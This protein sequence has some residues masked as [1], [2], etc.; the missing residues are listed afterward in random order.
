M[1]WSGNEIFLVKNEPSHKVDA[2]CGLLF[3]P[4]QF[5]LQFCGIFMVEKVINWR[6]SGRHLNSVWMQRSTLFSAWKAKIAC[7]HSRRFILCIRNLFTSASRSFNFCWFMIQNTRKGEKIVWWNSTDFWKIS[8]NLQHSSTDA[9]RSPEFRSI[10]EGTYILHLWVHVRTQFEISVTT[11][12][13]YFSLKMAIGVNRESIW[14]WRSISTSSKASFQSSR[15][16]RNWRLKRW[17]TT[18]TEMNLIS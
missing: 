7:K 15:A 12:E 4:W 10:R 2:P 13:S 3:W 9:E 11:K 16:I 8:Q 5:C 17:N 1:R 14:I 6:R 18:W